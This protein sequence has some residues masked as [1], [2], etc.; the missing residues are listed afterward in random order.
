MEEAVP[1]ILLVGVATLPA[2]LTFWEDVHPVPMV[3]LLQ[4]EVHSLL[5]D[6]ISC[7]EKASL[8]QSP[9]SQGP[10][11]PIPGNEAAAQGLSHPSLCCPYRPLPVTVS[12]GPAQPRLHHGP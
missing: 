10:S 4:N 6:A 12:P 5:V 8:R 11:F 2:P 9:F 7:R 1:P 3:E